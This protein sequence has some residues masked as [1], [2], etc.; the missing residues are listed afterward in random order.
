MNNALNGWFRWPNGPQAPEDPYAH[1]PTLHYDVPDYQYGPPIDPN[2]LASGWMQRAAPD[3]D[4]AGPV[5]RFAAP[6]ALAPNVDRQS[7]NVLAPTT[8]DFALEAAKLPVMNRVRMVTDYVPHLAKS[9]FGPTVS[10]Q[11]IG[12][13]LPQEKIPYMG[14]R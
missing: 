6:N 13:M 11:D 10:M 2:T 7:R 9:Y 4:H 5:G 14:K 8:F 3:G 12:A 1:I